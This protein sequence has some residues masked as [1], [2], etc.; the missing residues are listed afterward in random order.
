[1]D[2]FLDVFEVKFYKG[3][4]EIIFVICYFEGEVINR[5]VNYIYMNQGE[6]DKGG[7]FVDGM[8]WNDFLGLKKS[9]V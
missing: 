9:G 2:N 4:N 1:M 3:N 8:L 6:I 7:F 5:N